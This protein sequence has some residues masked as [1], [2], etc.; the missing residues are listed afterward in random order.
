MANYKAIA[1]STELRNEGKEYYNADWAAQLFGE[2]AA[3]GVDEEQARAM[4]G[5]FEFR[6]DATDG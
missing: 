3:L 2:S 1:E 5:Q 4:A 6:G